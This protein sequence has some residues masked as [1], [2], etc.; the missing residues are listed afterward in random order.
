M[1]RRNEWLVAT[2]VILLVAAGVAGA[3]W[4]NYAETRA[5]RQNTTYI[6]RTVKMTPEVGMLQELV[7]IDSSKPAGVAAAGRWVAEYLRR[8][9]IE[10]ETIESAPGM[11]NVYA[12][13]RGRQSGQGLMLFNHL[14][15][16]PPGE[17]WGLDPF[18]AQI[19]GDRIVGRGT[20]DMKAITICQLVAFVKV[21]RSGTAPAH[22]LVF[23]A[24]ADEETGSKYGM[25]WLLANR[26]DVFDGVAYGITEGGHTEMMRD[27]MTYFGIEIGGKMLVQA[28]IAGPDRETVARTR[29]ALE[30]WMFPRQPERI[31]PEVRVYF[32]ELSKSRLQFRELLVDVDAAVRD[33]KF[34]ILPAT[35][36]D[37]T[38]NSVATGPMREEDGRWKMLVTMVNLPD[39][40]PDRRLRWLGETI[41]PHGAKLAEVRVKEG[42]GVLSS[43]D[44]RIF[45]L[46]A[47]EAQERYGV[48]AGVEILYRSLT[49]SRFLRPKGIT[50]YGISPYAAT[51]F[52][53]L[54]IHGA[55]EAITVHAFQEGVTFMTEVVTEWAKG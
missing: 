13:I 40:D 9:G 20:L 39:E 37:L 38:Q 14:D 15:V 1:T 8:N 17:G 53:S 23:L 47:A 49:D 21:A 52:Q 22:D 54:A 5:L 4:W 31:L 2:S 12:R 44:S 28:D 51:Y 19:A 41:A 42:P 3:L 29:I 26:P 55:D 43:R 18:A 11:V 16:V 30:P 34:W 45:T 50:C 36:R 32:H 7:R 10:A 35:Y 33:G 27:Q 25:Q 24:T 48:P 6:P 46:L